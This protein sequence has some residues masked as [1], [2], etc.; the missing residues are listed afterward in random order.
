MLSGVVLMLDKRLRQQ[1]IHVR[2]VSMNLLF[3]FGMDANVSPVQAMYSHDHSWYGYPVVTNASS[4]L[5]Q[6]KAK[7]GILSRHI[8]SHCPCQSF[9][10]RGCCGWQVRLIQAPK[11]V[12]RHDPTP[13]GP[14]LSDRLSTWLQEND[15]STA[16]GGDLQLLKWLA[17]CLLT[18]GGRSIGHLYSYL[19]RHEPIMNG[20]VTTT[21]DQVSTKVGWTELM[22]VLSVGLFCFCSQLP[23]E[24]HRRPLSLTG[25]ICTQACTCLS[26]QQA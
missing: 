23:H 17:R 2:D 3:V 9:L 22:L 21:G 18:I 4:A 25:I 1:G 7:A 13:R 24:P 10:R 20:L 8:C 16:I 6:Q 5:Q 15:V 26:V 19:D 14:S 12:N 11:A